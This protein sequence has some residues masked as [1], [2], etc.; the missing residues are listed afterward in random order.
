[1][2]GFDDPAFFGDRWARRFEDLT[3]GP[4]PTAA[5]EFLAPLAGDG[6]RVLELAIGGGRVALPLAARGLAVEGVEASAAVAERLR[7]APGGDAV[8][9]AVADMADVPVDGPFRLVYL[10]WNSLFN[11]TSQERQVDCFR[12]VARV[13]EPGGTFVIECYVPDQGQGVTASAVTEDSATITVTHHDPVAQRLTK[14]HITLSEQGTRLLPVAHRYCWPG[15]LDLMAR[16]AGLRLR[17]RHADWHRVPFTSD[18]RSH[19]SVYE[20]PLP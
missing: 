18:S 6:G 12:N 19:V 1:M 20:R 9:V 13:L 10:V 3:S 16:L 5:V 8:P 7:A 2:S 14:Q 15:E 17:E 11:L 4:D